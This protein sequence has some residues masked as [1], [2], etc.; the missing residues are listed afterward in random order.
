[1]SQNAQGAN[2]GATRALTAAWLLVLVFS[3][4]LPVTSAQNRDEQP[5]GAN[6]E[7]DKVLELTVGMSGKITQV[8]LPGSLLKAKEVDPRRTPIVVRIDAVFPHGENNRYDLTWF[9]LE[10]GP[11]N[12]SDYLVREDGTSAAD[13]PTI[14]V[15][16][17]SI[18]P[19]N[20]L[21]PNEV[22]QGFLAR[23]GG[24]RV[25]VT[26][27]VVVWIGG[28]LAILFVGRNKKVES[29]AEID[30]QTLSPVD[31][32][33]QL[34][35]QA[36]KAGELGTADKA[37]LDMRILNFFRGRRN[38]GDVAMG[39]ALSAL[40]NDEQAGPLLTGLERWFY[41]KNPPAA[42][43]VAAM[44]QP[45]KNLT[46]AGDASTQPATAEGGAV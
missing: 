40:K 34:I 18:L 16:V 43:E 29:A 44:L 23:I 6:I 28:L 2:A 19:S 45:L 22:Q 41:S 25:A 13:L 17:K 26:L 27:A 32:I 35:E 30:Q 21:R 4:I 38:L 15:N 11:H 1:M 42:D 9:G 31:R 5:T 36:I 7:G 37:D 8:V 10:P 3:V 39:E 33:Q 24:Y 46:M 20:R 12:I 14:S